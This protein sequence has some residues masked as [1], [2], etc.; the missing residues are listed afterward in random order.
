MKKR[1]IFTLLLF[2]WL[3]P[4]TYA[5]LD[6]TVEPHT[7]WGPAPTSN[8]KAL[9]ENVALHFQE[10]LRDEHKVNGKLSIVYNADGP[11]AFLRTY[12]GGAPDEYKV[13]LTVTDTF[14]D[15]FTYQ[16]AHEFCHIMERHDTISD[17]NPNLWFQESLCMLASIWVLKQMSDTWEYRPPYPNWINYRH[18]LS[19]YAD[20]N[21]ER[22]GVQF[23]GKAEEWLKKWEQLLRDDYRN[24][25]THHLTVLQLS[26]KFLPIFTD[27]PEA[28]NAVRQMPASHSKMSQY[29][30]EWYKAVDP[31]DKPFVEAIA[32]V[33]GISVVPVVT[34]AINADVNRDGYVNLSDV[35]I[36]KSSITYPS[37]YD[38]DVNNDGKTDEVDVLVVKAI[39]IE[40]IVAAAPSQRR[41]KLTTWGALKRR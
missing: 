30:Q 5:E 4:F 36:V 3:L 20:A 9:C 26:Y 38:T 14:W 16:F 6:I 39:A 29:M 8:I 28:W 19:K 25:F 37:S 35:L 41:I 23:S 34:A 7:G 17:N 24:P 27:N 12:F 33:M 31:Q 1:I 13:G 40:A 21:V 32:T 10:N 18:Q 15:K 11:I 22:P 2:A